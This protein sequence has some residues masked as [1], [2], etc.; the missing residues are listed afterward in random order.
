MK[1]FITSVLSS[2]LTISATS[3]PI[4]VWAEEQISPG[5]ETYTPAQSVSREYHPTAEAMIFDGLV[6]RPLALG[7][8][9]VGAAI[10]IVTSP[11]SL[12]GG[13]AD[14]A[15]TA[16]VSEPAAYTFKRCLGCF[17]PSY[18]QRLRYHR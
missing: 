15:A 11:F 16:L 1:S 2:I 7:A 18:H 8:T 12:L 13:N 10:F 5:T 3:L 14:E 17:P 6:I 4:L 9:A